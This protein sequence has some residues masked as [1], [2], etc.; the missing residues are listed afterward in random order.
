MSKF[1]E[2]TGKRGTASR[3]LCLAGLALLLS[4]IIPTRLLAAPPTPSGD[5]P[6]IQC[7]RAETEAWQDSPHA[8]T[9]PEA[10]LPGA[11]CEDCHGAYVKDHPEAGVQQLTVDSSACQNCHTGTFHQWE[12]TT[13]AQAG[14]QCI[15]CHQSHS[16]AFRLTDEALCSS[17]HRDQSENFSHTAHGQKDVLCTDCHASSTPAQ[18]LALA[19]TGEIQGIT[20]PNHDFTAVSLEQCLECHDEDVHTWVPAAEHTP[21]TELLAMVRQVPALTTELESREQS[22]KILKIM[23]PV[24][25]GLGLGIG[26]ILGI[27]S[28]LVVGYMSRGGRHD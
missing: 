19:G 28:M 11:T 18:E 23:T 9:T 16:Q 4:L 20:A 8:K 1:L 12:E 24:S 7:H 2:I 6:C 14:V 21:D 5:E 13:H 17:C 15:S 3:W 27:V 25:L 10:G 22:N 26:G